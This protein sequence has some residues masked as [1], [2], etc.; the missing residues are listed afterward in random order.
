MQLFDAPALRVNA[1]GCW[2][3]RLTIDL[4][5]TDTEEQYRLQLRNGVLT[6]TS[7]LQDA[8]PD[9]TI[10]VTT[11]ALQ[12]LASTAATPDHLRHAGA[13]IE[14]DPSALQRLLMTLDAPHPNFA[15]VT[16]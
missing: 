14:G 8:A 4:V 7:A 6:Y 12:A 15:I 10:R 13:Q 3:E 5:L 11:P 9:A 16:P 1:P 2:D